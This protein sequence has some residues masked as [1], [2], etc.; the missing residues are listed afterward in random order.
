M[1]WFHAIAGLFLVTWAVAFTFSLRSPMQITTNYLGNETIEYRRLRPREQLLV[2]AGILLAGTLG[3]LLLAGAIP[4]TDERV[5]EERLLQVFGVVVLTL[6]FTGSAPLALGRWR[7]SRGVAA[8]DVVAP[9]AV[10]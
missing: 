7:G 4:W 10:L 5:P 8:V 9:A 2:V 3:G 6:G 1:R